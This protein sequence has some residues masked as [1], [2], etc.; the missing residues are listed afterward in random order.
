MGRADFIF[1]LLL[2]ALFVIVM[3][4][5]FRV[6][7][8]DDSFIGFDNAQNLAAGRGFDFNP[9]ERVLTTSAPL[10]VLLYAALSRLTGLQIVDIAQGVAAASC[11]TIVIFGY[12][13]MRRY[14]PPFGSLVS[15][16]TLVATPYL[17]LLW[18]HESYISVALCVLGLYLLFV[19][20]QLWGAAVIG[21]A[22]LF[23][24]EALIL[25]PIAA[26]ASR[27]LFGGWRY[28][29][30]AGLLAAA[31]FLA[32]I[33]VADMY[34]GTFISQTFSAKE[35]QL[36][37]PTVGPY[38]WGA[39]MYTKTVELVGVPRFL[40]TSL[41]PVA[42]ICWLTALVRGA[43]RPAHLV[44]LVWAL[45][46]T[47]FYVFA[48]MPIF[49]WFCF[50]FAPAL[51]VGQTTAWS[52]TRA[53]LK[54][55]LDSIITAIGK[56]AAVAVAGLSIVV[57]LA[58]SVDS[59]RIDNLVSFAV[60]ARYNVS[61]Y[62]A[63]GDWLRNGTRPDSTVAYAEIGQ[64]RYYS[65]RKIIDIEG[66]VNHGVA[67]HLRDGDSIWTFKYYRPTLYIDNPG[68]HSFVDPIEYDWFDRAYRPAGVVRNSKE[69][70]GGYTV[71]EL[72]DPSAVPAPDSL[73][74]NA[75]ISSIAMNDKTIEATIAP[76]AAEFD[77]IDVRVVSPNGCAHGDLRVALPSG[78]RIWD[79]KFSLQ[80]SASPMRIGAHGPPIP[81]SRGRAYRFVMTGCSGNRLAP[82]VELRSPSLLGLENVDASA[83]PAADAIS[84]YE[85]TDQ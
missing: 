85:R 13:F 32:W 24:P 33:A 81:G 1:A 15:T 6:Y 2:A 36:G 34:F 42:S 25:A 63:I 17:S 53:P 26:F 23:R 79:Q 57:P 82:R 68:W 21:I 51:V 7:A 29:V 83:G 64:L 22:A 35:A 45:A 71:Y 48:R 70:T 74:P 65:Q 10:A 5:F 18:S 31:P 16:S 78:Q 73:D 44:V 66:A 39:L 76:T 37:Y 49:I 54:P 8:M 56:G 19:R 41:W 27:T 61:P 75:S 69:S 47:V 50:Q 62:H 38:L 20:R 30:Y 80:R 9:G 4:G 58:I 77:A 11:L 52:P 46:L 43:I 84:V 60:Q 14:L 3:S 67:D 55:M 72:V 12:L 59:T 28:G 40:C